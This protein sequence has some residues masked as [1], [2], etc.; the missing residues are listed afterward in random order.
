ML[1]RN[2]KREAGA[3]RARDAPLPVRKPTPEDF[4]RGAILRAVFWKTLFHPATVYPAAVFALALMWSGLNGLS[5]GSVG[6][7]LA[8]IFAGGAAWIV[9]FVGR[10]G[11]FYARRVQELLAQRHQFEAHQ[12]EALGDQCREAGF[13]DGAKEAGELLAAYRKLRDFLVEREDGGKNQSVQ[14]YRILAEDTF[15]QGVSVLTQALSVFQVLREVNV[16]ALEAERDEWESQLRRRTRGPSQDDRTRLTQQVESHNARIERYHER[17]ELIKQLIVQADALE[18]ALENAHL[19]L[20]ELVGRDP[21]VTLTIG[22]SNGAATQLEKAVA[23]ARRVEEKLRGVGSE[24]SS[25]ADEQYRRAGQ[26][27]REARQTQGE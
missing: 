20:V 27:A 10:G 25:E 15:R 26:R 13:H 22:T 7:M 24:A 12:V 9:N 18:A 23:A 5:S 8:S 21:S 1:T 14:R 16:E 4:K 6:V 19:E 17:E 11:T 2:I 3:A